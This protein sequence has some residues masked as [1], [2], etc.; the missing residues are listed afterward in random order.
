MN[1]VP[2]WEFWPG[3]RRRGLIC[4]QRD[5]ADNNFRL[6]DKELERLVQQYITKYESER[7]EIKIDPALLK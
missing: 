4:L 6:L 7:G 5:L 1:R 3:M 2:V